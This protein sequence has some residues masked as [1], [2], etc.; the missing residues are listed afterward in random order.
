MEKTTR[1]IFSVDLAQPALGFA[2]LPGMITT[3]KPPGNC[4][5][6]RTAFAWQNKHLNDRST[7]G[8]RKRNPTIVVNGTCINLSAATPHPKS[9]EPRIKKICRE[10]AGMLMKLS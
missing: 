2:R 10:T 1:R 7:E 8:A 6:I 5:K 4:T 9:C 3:L